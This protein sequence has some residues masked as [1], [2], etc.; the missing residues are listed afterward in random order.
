MRTHAGAPASESSGRRLAVLSDLLS[1]WNPSVQVQLAFAA[2]A[3]AA[4]SLS[5]PDSSSSSTT[6][7]SHPFSSSTAVDASSYKN[8]LFP[9]AS[10]P[11][12]PVSQ[13]PSASQSSMN[14]LPFSFVS[15]GHDCDNSFTFTTSHAHVHAPASS[16][17]HFAFSPDSSNGS[18]PSFIRL[19]DLCHIRT[20]LARA[21][22]ENLQY[23]D[24]PMVCVPACTC[25]FIHIYIYVCVCMWQ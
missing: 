7:P 9:R 8:G 4:R 21:E 2:E 15:N 6:Y 22:L 1:D 14:T 25:K 19:E 12:N 5:V 11:L 24:R 20:T 10:Q 3:A 16:L 18:E 23:D 17:N 13:S